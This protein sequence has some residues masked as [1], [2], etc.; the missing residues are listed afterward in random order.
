MLDNN[1]AHLQVGDVKELCKLDTV[2]RCLVEHNDKLAVGKHRPRRV[3]LQ[4]VVNILG[5]ART[6]R[7]ILTHTLPEGKEEVCG[8]LMLKEQ[9]NLVNKDKGVPAFRPVLGNAV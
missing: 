5:D 2:C 4:E 3:A 8:I 7:P 6:V 9:V 1:I